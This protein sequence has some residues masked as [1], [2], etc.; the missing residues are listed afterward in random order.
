MIFSSCSSTDTLGPTV[1][2]F[3]ACDQREMAAL[4]YS[5][6]DCR[7]E[8]PTDAFDPHSDGMQAFAICYGT[9][10]CGVRIIPRAGSYAGTAALRHSGACSGHCH[11][12]GGLKMSVWVGPGGACHGTRFPPARTGNA[13]SAARTQARRRPNLRARLQLTSSW[14]SRSRDSRLLPMVG[15]RTCQRIKIYVATVYM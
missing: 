5:C 3:N 4:C 14:P 8:I 13:R 15:S 11:S 6:H 2:V 1:P 12:E 10:T 7:A 9:M